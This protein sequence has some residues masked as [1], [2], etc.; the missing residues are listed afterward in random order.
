MRRQCPVAAMIGQSR[1]EA[2]PVSARNAKV[3]PPP[4][5]E[6]TGVPE[7]MLDGVLLPC[8]FTAT[9]CASW[10]GAVGQAGEHI[11][12]DGRV[13]RNGSEC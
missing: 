7:P 6:A 9:T 10:T 1:R 13:R 3:L 8:A 4:G 5:M 2:S 11:A 12:R